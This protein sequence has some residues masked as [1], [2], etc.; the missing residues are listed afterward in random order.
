MKSAAPLKSIIDNKEIKTIDNRLIDRV[1]E[2]IKAKLSDETYD[3]PFTKKI[4]Q[5][6]FSEAD[7]MN[8]VEYCVEKATYSKGRAFVKIFSNKMNA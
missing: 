7:I 1:H 2:T 5:S 4:L 8:V 3:K 6:G